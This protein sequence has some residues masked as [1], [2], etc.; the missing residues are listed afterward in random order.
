NPGGLAGVWAEE[1]SRDALYAA[2]RRR[3]TF[4]TSGPRIP[5]RLFAGADFSPALCADPA[6]VEQ[7]CA[8][9]VPMGG[10]LTL[11]PNAVPMLAVAASY[12]PGTA[13]NPGTPLQRIQIVKGWVGADGAHH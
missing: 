8:R 12:D 1:N 13:A 7:G 11:P 9:G 4:G 10:D 3:E 5:V 2:L 6:F